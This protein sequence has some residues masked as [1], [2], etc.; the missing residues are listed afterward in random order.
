MACRSTGSSTVVGRS[1][2][3]AQTAFHFWRIPL[4]PTLHRHVIGVEASLAEQLLDVPV[5]Q[6]KTQIPTHRQ[7]DDLRF[8]LAP[9]KQTADR[10]KA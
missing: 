3:G 1:E 10:M 9:L 4:D 6:G 2:P 7:K 5:R 8:K